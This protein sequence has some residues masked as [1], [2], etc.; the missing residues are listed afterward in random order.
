MIIKEVS[1]QDR[2]FLQDVIFD[3][4]LVFIE[5][6]KYLIECYGDNAN[7]SWQYRANLLV[8]NIQSQPNYIK[9]VDYNHEFCFLSTEATKHGRDNP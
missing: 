3:E 6:I 1:W 4:P 2:A 5:R 9:Q 7:K 8:L